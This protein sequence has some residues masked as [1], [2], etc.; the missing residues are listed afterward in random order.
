MSRLSQI[1]PSCGAGANLAA[2][3]STMTP[4]SGLRWEA[5]RCGSVS[6]ARAANLKLPEWEVFAHPGPHR[7]SRE[8]QIRPVPP[9]TEWTAVLER[10]VLVERLR[11]VQALVGFTRIQ[12][13]GDFDD[14]EELPED[15]RAPLSR[16]QPRWLP[17]VEVRGEGIFLQ[18]REDG[19]QGWVRGGPAATQ[20][21]QVF[22]ETH[23]RWRQSR[24]LPPLP[25]TFPNLRYLLLHTIAH[26][27][28]RQ[29][30]L[31]CGYA[32]ASIRERIYSLNPEDE[33]GPMAGVLLYT[34]ATD[35]E[36][37]LGGL[38]RLGEPDELGRHIS[39][40]L[41]R[42][43]LCASDPLCAEHVPDQYGLHGAACHACL[44][45]P[46]TSCERGNKYLDRTLLVPTVAEPG[47]ALFD[48]L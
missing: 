25:V 6:P 18:F 37:T 45:L 32:M 7:A 41:E 44:F 13:P 16:E 12:S 46:E 26:A 3:P 34:A 38:V 31:D 40:A 10:V 24:N 28:I 9:P 23:A 20:R 43:S 21:E 8:F 19:L 33:D 48:S 2:L 47:I 4:P 17:A 5:R 42:A 1:S 29:L 30:S 27:L 39:F 11:V 36:G 15:R 22:H 14:V 35:S